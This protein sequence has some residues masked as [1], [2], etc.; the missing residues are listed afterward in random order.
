MG[1]SDGDRFVK[2]MPTPKQ[3]AA[4]RVNTAGGVTPSERV[5]SIAD[6]DAVYDEVELAE[7]QSADLEEQRRTGSA[8][9]T[10]DVLWR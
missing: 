5:P 3:N 6:I 1:S 2:E 4:Q 7:E 8:R 10:V 9:P